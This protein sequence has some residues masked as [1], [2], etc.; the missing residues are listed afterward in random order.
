MKLF[1]LFF[2]VFLAYGLVFWGLPVF[3][4]A[5][6]FPVVCFTH[7]A[8]IGTIGFLFIILRAMQ[9][10]MRKFEERKK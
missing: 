2:Q 1:T 8:G 6:Y 9:I 5:P 4:D 3:F 10:A 7:L